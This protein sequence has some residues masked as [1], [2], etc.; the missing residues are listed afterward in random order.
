MLAPAPAQMLK[1]GSWEWGWWRHTT[2]KDNGLDLNLFLFSY[3]IASSPK[4][5]VLS[6]RKRKPTI[7]ENQKAT[8]A[9]NCDTALAL[10][11]ARRLFEKTFREKM[12]AFQR[13]LMSDNSLRWFTLAK[14]KN[15]MAF[16]VFCARKNERNILL[17]ARLPF[18]L[19]KFDVTHQLTT[20]AI[21]AKLGRAQENR[22]RELERVRRRAHRLGRRRGG[23]EGN[24][25]KGVGWLT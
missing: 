13:G 22:L 1:D 8:C 15:Y 19:R 5:A 7:Q 16:N 18:N 25:R 20:E 24:N 17:S 6:P 14:T 21:K 11:S 9:D 3:K 12:A 23:D 4:E 10:A 2:T